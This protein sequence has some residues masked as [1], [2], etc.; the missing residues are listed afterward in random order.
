M[1]TAPVATAPTIP[2]TGTISTTAPITG[3][4]T[5]G[6]PCSQNGAPGTWGYASGGSASFTCIPY[7][8]P[9][10]STAATTAPVAT[11]P[12]TAATTAPST[13]ATTAP[14]ATAPSTAATTAPAAG[15]GTGTGG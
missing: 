15:T 1:F 2:A 14:V 9:A 10:P 4:Y 7:G 6:A 3:G 8:S 5:F 11:A 13:A 12:S